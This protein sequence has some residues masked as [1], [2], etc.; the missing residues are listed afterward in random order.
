MV[1]TPSPPT[2]PDPAATAAA[3]AAGKV[4]TATNQ[5]ELNMVNQ[6]TPQGNLTYDQ[7]GKWHDG[8]PKF[9]ATTSYSP[10]E[11]KIYDLGTQTRTN[12]G[13]IG[14]DQ[15]GRIGELLGTPVNLNNDAI[16]AR[17]M[18]LGR[19]R[20]DPLLAQRR[21]Q[22]ETDLL[23]RGITPGTEAYSRAMQSVGQQENDAYNQLLL[24]GRGQSVQEALAQRN[25]PINEITALLSGSQV[26][27]PNFVNSPQTQVA[28]TDY[29]GI[30]NNNY[31]GQMMGYQQQVGAQNAMI[32]GLASLG[33]AALGGWGMGGFKGFGG[34]GGR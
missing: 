8:T 16:E 25:Q 6:V 18:E 22:T 34:M 33:G 31:Q 27:Q 17:L 29:A 5:Q 24:Q 23:N 15:S 12:V 19:T 10:A 14:V 4:K 1:S 2:P 21:Q 11:Q 7:T 13:Q 20:L 9:S 30:V 28:P 32:G 3:D 26:S